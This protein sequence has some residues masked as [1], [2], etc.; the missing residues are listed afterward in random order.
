MKL[1]L[2]IIA[3]LIPFQ[4]IYGQDNGLVNSGK[5]PFAALHSVDMDDVTRLG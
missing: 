3:A 1:Y 4:S 2:I 5:S